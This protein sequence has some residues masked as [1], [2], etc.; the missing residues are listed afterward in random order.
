[1]QSR[2]DPYYHKKKTLQFATQIKKKNC[3]Y[4]F[5]VLLYLLNY[6]YWK[7]IRQAN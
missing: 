4:I 6:F 1:M 7:A 5:T 3:N 2:S